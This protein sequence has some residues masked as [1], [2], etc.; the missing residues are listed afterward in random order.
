[1]NPH[2]T[3]TRFAATVLV[4]ATYLALT[5]AS[6]GCGGGGNDST[7]SSTAPVGIFTPDTPTP[8]NGSVTLLQGT[9]SGASVNVR[10]TVTQ[11]DNF[12]GAAFRITYDPAA[13]LF[14][15]MTSSS[16][17]LNAGITDTSQLFF[18]ADSANSP[19]EVVI[20]ATRLFPATPLPAAPTADL[21]ILNFVARLA[22]APGA[23]VGRLDFADPVHNQVCNGTVSPPGCGPISVTWSGG[24]MSAQ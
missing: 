21:V 4:A 14:N 20:T 3:M 5:V 8:E 6:V 10:V 13:L 12:F 7:T 23:E 15:G 2:R 1:M 16:S 11:V 19:G 9:T 22:I 17:F 18:S 24:G